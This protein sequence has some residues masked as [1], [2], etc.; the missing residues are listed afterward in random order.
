[1]ITSIHRENT[2]FLQKTKVTMATTIAV[3]SQQNGSMLREHECAVST[4]T[5]NRHDTSVAMNENENEKKNDTK[6]F[7][8]K[9]SGV[10]FVE[11]HE[12]VQFAL[13]ST[14]SF[15]SPIFSCDSVESL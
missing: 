3:I 6:T 1:M 2:K 5:P 15:E 10:E 4:I 14:R 8:I 12:F 9:Y 7:A 11:Y 13:T